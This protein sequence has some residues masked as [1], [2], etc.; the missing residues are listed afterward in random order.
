MEWEMAES[1]AEWLPS[2][3]YGF[4]SPFERMTRF[5]WRELP[6]VGMR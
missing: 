4:R 5:R 1:M 6:E 2:L 3:S